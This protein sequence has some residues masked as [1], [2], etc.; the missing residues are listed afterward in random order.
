[1][2]QGMIIVA[3][4]T[5]HKLEDCIQLLQHLVQAAVSIGYWMVV[6]YLYGD[7]SWQYSSVRTGVQF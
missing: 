4:P 5:I 3:T 2:L 1:M 6:R 7:F